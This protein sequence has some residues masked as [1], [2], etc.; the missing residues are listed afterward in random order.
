MRFLKCIV[1][2]QLLVLSALFCRGNAFTDV[3]GG[4]G[5]SLRNN[6]NTGI[7]YGLNFYKGISNGIGFGF[8]MGV[9]QINL[10]NV[11]QENLINGGTIDMN[12]KYFHF[13]PMLVFQLGRS[14][15]FSGYFTGGIAYLTD[16]YVTVHTWTDNNIWPL[17]SGYDYYDHSNQYLK[18]MP[19]RIGVG[20]MQYFRLA[21]SFHVFINEDIGVFPKSLENRV[22]AVD[23]STNFYHLTN[24]QN[25]LNDFFSPT[26]ISLRIGLAYITNSGRRRYY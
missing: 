1:L 5:L 20:F 10:S 12:A 4:A 16:G 22:K 11:S 19:F 3:W 21:G 25:N 24:I 8:T 15:H 9:Q 2:I 13:A 6:Y 7:S 26:Y 23:D 14:G 17:G 18:Q